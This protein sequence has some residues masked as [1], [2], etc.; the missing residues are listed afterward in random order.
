M[1]AGDDGVV[2]STED[3]GVTWV[4]LHLGITRD[5]FAIDEVA[6]DGHL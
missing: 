3:G 6:G 1:A 5:V 2:V 4:Q